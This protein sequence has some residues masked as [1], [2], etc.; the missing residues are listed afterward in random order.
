MDDILKSVED[1][2]KKFV[3]GTL[4]KLKGKRPKT[5]YYGSIVRLETLND[6]ALI[7]LNSGKVE[8]NGL[9]DE[10][11]VC[12]MKSKCAE[13][14]QIKDDNQAL[15]EEL[16]H[17]H[18]RIEDLRSSELRMRE[19]VGTIRNYLSGLV[20]EYGQ[21]FLAC[22]SGRGL[23]PTAE[24]SRFVYDN[25]QNLYWHASYGDSFTH[26]RCANPTQRGLVPVPGPSTEP[27]PDSQYPQVPHSN[28]FNI[29]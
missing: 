22:S 5:F 3:P 15:R 29:P 1:G 26:H 6:L 14:F 4:W 11:F 7:D 12:W 23:V 9:S 18:R 8:M 27:L 20:D 13:P 25:L 17:A 2:K 16:A 28:P 21:V 24:Y 19:R 10:H